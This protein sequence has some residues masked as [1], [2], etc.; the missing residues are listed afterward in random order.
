MPHLSTIHRPGSA[1]WSAATPED[2][3]RTTMKKYRW[4]LVSKPLPSRRLTE[5][6]TLSASTTA[7]YGDSG[8]RRRSVRRFP[9]VTSIAT[10]P[11]IQTPDESMNP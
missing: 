3:A 5:S 1:N 7:R 4:K 6:F 9:I 8:R 10:A 2:S 11:G